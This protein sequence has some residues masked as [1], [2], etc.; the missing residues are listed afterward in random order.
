M[1]YVWAVGIDVDNNPLTGS[2]GFFLGK[3]A[4][5][6]LSAIHG[7]VTPNNPISLPIA[8]GVDVY[9]DRYN[10]SNGRF[11]HYADA[12]IVVDDQGN[13]LTLTGDI[14]GISGSSKLFF[15]TIDYTPGNGQTDVSLCS[16]FASI[17][18]SLAEGNE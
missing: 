18:V 3:G 15:Q 13:T 6:M 10:S 1:E 12:T 9:V 14:P 17:S 4:E 11:E 16:I 2:P 5:Y 8:D 7:V